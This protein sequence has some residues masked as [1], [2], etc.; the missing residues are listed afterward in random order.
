MM[1]L[2]PEAEDLLEQ[3]YMREIEHLPDPLPATDDRVIQELVRRELLRRQDVK[4]SLTKTGRTEAEMAV[5]RHRLAE[6]LLHDVIAVRDSQVDSAACEFEHSLHHG[7]AEHI[8]TLLGHP[9]TCPHGRP[10]PPG[11]CCRE[12]AG[13]SS[14]IAP[15]A[16]MKSGE[17]GTIAYLTSHQPDTVQKLMSLGVLPGAPVA[18]IQIFPSVVFQVNQTQVAIDAGLAGNIFVRRNEK[19]S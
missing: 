3:L 7:I 13:A 18:V 12:R 5:R 10:I 6:R 4:V 14:V 9:T 16:A 1:H 17:R 15:L 8:C 2:S 11:R 19:S